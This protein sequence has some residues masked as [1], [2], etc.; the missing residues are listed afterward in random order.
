MKSGNHPVP[1]LLMAQMLH[2]LEQNRGSHM[3][4]TR[5]GRIAKEALLLVRKFMGQGDFQR[6]SNAALKAAEAFAE[7]AKHSSG[8]ASKLAYQRA[9]SLVEI[10]KALRKEEP[11]P[12]HL[13]DA[14]DSFFPEDMDIPFSEPVVEDGAPVLSERFTKEPEPSTEDASSL[15]RSDLTNSTPHQ[16]LNGISIACTLVEMLDRA[17]R[18]IRIMVQNFTDVKTVT[19]GTQSCEINLLDRLIAKSKEGVKI[20]I[21]IR[22]PEAFGSASKHFQEAVE[23]LLNEAPDI[24]ILVCAQMHIKSLIIDEVEVLEGSANFTAKG[25]SGIGEQATWTTNSEF[26]TQFIHRFDQYWAHQGSECT[27]CKNRTCEVHPLTRRTP[28]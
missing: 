18:S 19:V 5:L 1:K 25:L 14:L 3:S 7:L 23:K 2:F 12:L 10:T 15:E 27:A 8:S 13:V 9:R 21:I 16:L 26:V 17:N 11:L 20:R 4:T 28:S 24:E 22:E 6:A